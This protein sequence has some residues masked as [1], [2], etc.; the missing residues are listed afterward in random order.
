LRQEWGTEEQWIKEGKCAVS[1]MRLSCCRIFDN[2][3]RQQLFRLA[4][5]PGNLR[6]PLAL[7]RAVKHSWL[8]TL[9]E[10]PIEIGA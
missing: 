7:P 3:A 4:D 9:R 2:Q 8:T 5:N 1:W 6:R 10:E